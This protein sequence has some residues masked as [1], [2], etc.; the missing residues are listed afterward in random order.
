M[1]A[2]VV[3]HGFLLAAALLVEIVGGGV[4]QVNECSTCLL[5]H[6]A[7]PLAIGVVAAFYLAVFPLVAR[8]ERHDYWRSALFL[9]VLNELLQI[10]AESINQFVATRFLHLVHVCR[11]GRAGYGAAHLLV[12]HRTN[13]VV[14]ELD[15][16]IVA[17]LQR[18]VHLVPTAFVEIG[19]CG[20]SRLGTVHARDF[21]LVEHGAG[22]RTPA[23]HAVL[24]LVLVLYGGVAGDEHHGLAVLTLHTHRGQ[25]HVLHHGL[26]RSQL[27]VGACGQ[28][29]GGRAGIEFSSELACVDVVFVEV[30]AL[31]PLA[32]LVELASRY[33]VEVYV[34]YTL[35]LAHLFE[36][37]A[38]RFAHNFAV[39]AIG[40]ARS[41]RHEYGVGS[42]LSD[43]L[44]I[45]AHIS[46]IGVDGLL[47]ARFLYCH[48]DGVVSG[49]WYGGA[50]ASAVVGAVVVV[51]N[52]HYHPVA[53]FQGFAHV[54]PQFVVECAAAHAS[55][56]LVLDGYLVVV[57]VFVLKVS[58]SPLAVAAVAERTVAHGRVAYEK[59]HRVVSLAT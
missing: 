49:A 57:E 35:L 12:V 24:V 21:L 30:I 41:E 7:I 58:P 52:R 5:G 13:V 42:C 47:L 40:V 19:A 34:G 33:F 51:P 29:L 4:V 16:H 43:V 10:P 3:D 55:E 32:E 50:C 2:I 26:Q 23:P 8:C 25:G 45:L 28:S 20:A 22:L 18:V 27:R 31:L 11:V 39:V 54:G 9:H 6:F 36:P 56:G 38:V 15:E 46:A 48:V 44:D 59:Q 14:A 17:R 53:R 1:V 37:L